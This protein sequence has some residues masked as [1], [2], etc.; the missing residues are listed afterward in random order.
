MLIDAPDQVAFEEPEL[1]S[2]GRALD[3]HDQRTLLVRHRPS[4]PRDRRSDG[5]GPRL[6]RPPALQIALETELAQHAGQQIAETLH[7]QPASGR[8]SGMTRQSSSSSAG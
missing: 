4:V 1:V 5:P 6:D 7:D 3:L 8:R 2:P